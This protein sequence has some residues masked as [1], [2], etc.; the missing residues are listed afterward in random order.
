MLL[1]APSI[2]GEGLTFTYSGRALTRDDSLPPS[3]RP[4]TIVVLAWCG[5]LGVRVDGGQ[6][7][8]LLAHPPSSILD[9][10]ILLLFLGP[11]LLTYWGRG[12][13][14]LGAAYVGQRAGRAMEGGGPL[15]S[16][17]RCGTPHLE[18]RASQ[19]GGNKFRDIYIHLYFTF[20]QQGKNIREKNA[21]FPAT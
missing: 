3:F 13:K 5:G 17:G 8:S 16:P 11:S 7:F 1:A 21:V 18:E 20:V 14:T 19:H 9:F 6:C 12:K 15:F 4:I 10:S 2:P